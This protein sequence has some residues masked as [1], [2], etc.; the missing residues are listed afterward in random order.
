M[1]FNRPFGSLLA[2]TLLSTGVSHATITVSSLWHMGETGTVGANNRPQDSSDGDGNFNNFGGG[3]T[4]QIG[5]DAPPPG[6]SAYLKL[7]GL[8]DAY[9]TPSPTQVIP[10]DNFGIELWVRVATADLNQSGKK[11][12]LLGN[13]TGAYSITMNDGGSGWRASTNGTSYIGDPVPATGDAWTHLALIRNNGVNEFYVNGVLAGSNTNGTDNNGIIHL[14]INSG[15][16]NTFKG[17]VDEMRLFTFNS[18]EFAPADLEFPVPDSFVNVGPNFAYPAV[19]LSTAKSS[20]FRI[21]GF[22]NDFATITDADGLS[23]AGAAGTKHVINVVQE[24]GVEVGT[25]PLISYSGTIGGLGFAGLQLAQPIGRLQASLVNNTTTSTIDLV[26]TGAVTGDV[27]W[28]GASNSTWDVDGA[29][30]W[31]F[32]FSGAPT[33]FFSGDTVTFD[34]TASTGT[35]NLVGSILPFNVEINNSSRDYTFSGTG[36][37]GSTALQ[38]FGTGTVTFTNNNTFTGSTMIGDGTVKLGNGTTP[39]TLGTGSI[40]NNATLII[41]HTGESTISSALTGGGTFEKRGTGAVT[42]SGNNS[43]TGPLVF[44]AGIIR[45]GSLTALGSNTEATTVTAGTTLDING[46]GFGSEPI[47]LNGN[48]V[49][50]IGALVNNGA[51]EQSGAA[52]TLV[53]LASD[54]SIGGTARWDMRGGTTVIDGNFKL[55]KVGASQVNFVS[56]TVGVKDLVVNSGAVFIEFGATVNNDNPGSITLNAGGSFGVGSYGAPVTVLKPIVLNGGSLGTA[57]TGTNGDATIA[58]GVTLSVPAATINPGNGSTLTLSGI[59]SGSGGIDKSGAGTLL[60]GAA[61]TYSGAT[62]VTAGTLSLTQPSLADASAIS[63]AATGAILNLNFSGADTVASLSIGG[64]AQASGQSYGATGSGANVI[65]DVHFTGTGRLFVGTPATGGYSAWETLNGIAGAGPEVDS[66]G[67]GV[68]NGIEFVIG[69]DPSG[70]NSNS[71]S[72]LPTATT[73]ATYLTFVFRRTTESNASNPPTV[74]YGSTLSG[75]TTAVA[76]APAGTPVLIT[77]QAGVGFTGDVVTVK[78][79]RALAASGKLFARLKVTP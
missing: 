49:G 8:A 32:T 35:V 23:V 28:N 29:N 11:I 2:A 42:L 59:V 79:P 19:A 1:S 21:G 22:S 68:P 16:G 73:D 36:I 60:L 48:G 78:I 57:A 41:D 40:E 61:N 10:A 71:R 25:Y 54:S 34:D 74:E 47:I 45:S 46:F 12:L 51:A 24:G 55:T 6:S 33:H 14:G 39:G 43:F 44:T 62:T 53:T 63:I 27:T 67:D 5:T 64:T 17:D 31:E 52:A 18:G 37:T 30:N 4:G 72:L 13:T 56:G 77:T 66:D 26:V 58:A 50:G 75:W 70:P 7:F 20:T 38:K 3:S 69:G 76:G 65:D 9:Y 15:G